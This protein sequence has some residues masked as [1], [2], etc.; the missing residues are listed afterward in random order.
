MKKLMLMGAVLG[1]MI[2]GAAAA[3][4]AP[5]YSTANVNMRAGP[6]T[7]FPRVDLIPEGTLVD[8][9]GCLSDESW[10]DVV[11]GGSRGWVIS[12]YLAFEYRG[13][14]MPLPDVGLAAIRLPAIRF[15]ANDYWGRYYTKR[16]WY[17]ERNRWYAFKP[18]P[19]PGWRAPPPGER[20]AGWWR[21][22][23]K[24]YAGMK[25]PQETWSR[26]GRRDDRR[27]DDRRR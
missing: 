2:G 4:A 15:V 19:R 17:N 11:W 5:A 22:G 24:P 1:A 9:K 18:R 8:I 21:A 14:Y 23:Y 3:H 26:P 25:P 12:E 13:R 27:H 7:D 16:P 20:K 10:C 6:D